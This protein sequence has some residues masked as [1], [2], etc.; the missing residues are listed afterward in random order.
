MPQ[1]QPEGATLV[2]RRREDVIVTDLNEEV[3]LLDPVSVEMYSLAEVG[4]TVWQ[5]LPGTPE[6]VAEQVTAS[7]DVEWNLALQ[8]IRSLLGDLK[9]AGLVE[10]HA[11]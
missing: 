10:A 9:A 1:G 2:Y 4:R 11:L 3:V 6:Q 7:Y 8:D 5:A